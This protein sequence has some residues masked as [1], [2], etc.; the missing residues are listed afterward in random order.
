M[1]KK[2][3][4][5]LGFLLLI[6]IVGCLGNNSE[7]TVSESHYDISTS[8]YEHT[9][10]SITSTTFTYY[11]NTS[12]ATST[13][14]STISSATTSSATT[15][16]T[17]TGL[18][19][20]VKVIRVIDGDTIEVMFLNGSI[21]RVRMLGID[22]PET[23]A[24]R[25]KPNEYDSITDLEC[26]ASWGLKAKQYVKTRL[27]GTYVYIEFDSMAGK[28]GYYKRLLAYVYYD[29]TDFT[30]ELIKRGYARVYTEGDFEKEFE[31]VSYQNLAI[32][33]NVGLWGACK[34]TYTSTGASVSS[35]TVVIWK[36]HY[37]AAG[38]D[39]QNLND[40]YVVLKNI[41][42]TAVSLKGWT[43]KDEAGKTFRFPS[44]VLEPGK[45]VTIHTGSGTNTATDL[46]WGSGR[47]IWNNDGDT[48][49]L[50]NSKGELID[51][52]SW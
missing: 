17:N 44:F 33:N 11:E 31:Y 46:Y 39:H 27:E 1:K 50:Y 26:L 37:D 23:T 47:A 9:S 16:P 4:I 24:S 45:T 35:S 20:K 7:Q 40:E 13:M 2:L 8:T 19:E 28:R 14:S 3:V 48:V 22:T 21:E 15:S 10:T 34:S 38:N 42:S 51:K 32:K 52:Y 6:A 5:V 43:L 49:Y 41:G 36:V 12:T 18:R 30:A 29:N 25:N